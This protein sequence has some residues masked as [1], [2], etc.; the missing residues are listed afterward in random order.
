MR[1]EMRDSAPVRAMPNLPLLSASLTGEAD[2]FDTVET[3]VHAVDIKVEVFVPD[4]TF[5]QAAL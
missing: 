4:E 5:M 1:T 3:T 2:R